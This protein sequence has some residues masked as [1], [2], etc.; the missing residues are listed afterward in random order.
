[1]HLPLVLVQRQRVDL[2]VVQEVDL[3]T[4]VMLVEQV[5]TQVEQVHP[6]TL[7]LLIPSIQ[8][9]VAVVHMILMD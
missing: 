5:D 6:I 8:E 4:M 2:E 3:I 1:M 9:V 7:I